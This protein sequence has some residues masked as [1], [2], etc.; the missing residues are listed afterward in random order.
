MTRQRIARR[1]GAALILLLVGA[2]GAGCA[3][4]VVVVN[5]DP[6]VE[7]LRR[8]FEA[9]GQHIYAS[10]GQT[11]RSTKELEKY[12]PPQEDV[13]AILRSPNDGQPYVIHWGVHLANPELAHPVLRVI[14][15][16]KDGAGGVRCV[17]LSDG[18]VERM[19]QARFDSAVKARK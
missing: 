16:E 15:N 13:S 17:L 18:S 1:L 11:P 12:L 9:Y 19:D 10:K 6:G 3:P 2:I 8:I 5:E 7:N 14:A 4:S